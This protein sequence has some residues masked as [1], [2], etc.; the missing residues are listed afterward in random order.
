MPAEPANDWWLITLRGILALSLGLLMWPVCQRAPA[1]INMFAGIYFLVDGF[2]ALL[3][4]IVNRSKISNR[5][6]LLADSAV[7]IIAGIVIMGFSPAGDVLPLSS[8]IAVI[9]WALLTGICEVII[10]LRHKG[11]LP[12]R[13]IF[14]T[15]GLLSVL[16]GVLLIIGMNIDPSQI[17]TILVIYWIILG[18]LF[19]ILGFSG[20]SL[21]DQLC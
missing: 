14:I 12:G 7:G 13:W 4:A 21:E 9:L 3:I 8:I 11:A 20:R 10:P 1:L 6:W 5:L 2:L 17:I 18:I 15:G 19:M 16:L